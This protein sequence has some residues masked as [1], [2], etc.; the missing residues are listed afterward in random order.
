MSTQVQH[1]RGTTAQHASLTGAAG[2]VTVDTSKN[3]V[4][5]HDGSTA[6][7]HPAATEAAVALKANI[8]SP[9]FTGTP[10]APTVWILCDHRRLVRR[11][12][13]GQGRRRLV[14]P[15]VRGLA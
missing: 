2:E 12:D 14:A 11:R 4:V 5:V 13:R 15:G 10:E 9:T 1:R 6:G 7:G 8:A 3:V